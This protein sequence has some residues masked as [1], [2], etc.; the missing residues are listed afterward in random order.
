MASLLGS[1]TREKVLRYLVQNPYKKAKDISDATG[2]NYKNTFKILK[3]LV[4]ENVLLEKDKL[5]FVSSNF[6]MNVKILSDS[7]MR[8][9][10]KEFFFRNK[11]DLY[12]T[13]TATAKDDKITKKVNKIMDDWIIKK[14]NDWY[15]KFYDLQNKEY[16]E[17]KKILS[18]LESPKN[19]LEIGCGTGR[20]TFKL[21]KDFKKIVAI[22]EKKVNID[23]CKKLSKTKKIQFLHST[24]K[25]FKSN[26]KFDVIFFSWM[27]LHYH[28]DY[29]EIIKHLK[30]FLSK[31]GVIIIFDAYFETEYIKILQLIRN[32]DMADA[33]KKKEKL[34]DYL[35]KE[36]G[37]L[38]NQILFT[39]Y[40]FPTIEEL[41][42]N[43]KIELTLEESHIWTKEDENKIKEYLQTKKDP[44]KVQEGLVVSVI[45][46]K[47]TK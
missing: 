35:A 17:I 42:N 30:K 26:K 1:Q 33:K 40:Q 6:I 4:K 11:Y 41:V 10:S 14:L 16:K 37:N 15:S 8:N 23:Y 31:K 27:G 12:N 43:F 29:D 5:Y 34:N 3:E 28:E 44:L 47:S 2:L 36:F 20:L 7:L 22:D 46:N 19:M 21:A 25:D 9:Y 45:R 13:L 18:S 32:R 39:E 24:A 38:S